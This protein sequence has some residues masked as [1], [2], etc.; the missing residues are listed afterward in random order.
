MPEPLA[1]T[2]MLKRDEGRLTERDNEDDATGIDVRPSKEGRGPVARPRTVD[3][4][5]ASGL[6]E[7]GPPVLLAKR[8]EGRGMAL[9]S[10]AEY[11]PA[12]VS[13]VAA[14]PNAQAELMR[15]RK[16]AIFAVR[17]FIMR[18]EEPAAAAFAESVGRRMGVR[19]GRLLGVEATIGL[20]AVVLAREDGLSMR[21]TSAVAFAV[22]LFRA[23]AESEARGSSG[24]CVRDVGA[25]AG[26]DAVGC[27]CAAGTSRG[28]LVLLS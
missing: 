5:D 19:S 9:V 20:R 28:V 8:D 24:V 14:W 25:A 13:G 1:P 17:S 3:V 26:G 11:T 2:P 22:L 16:A 23:W 18:T 10:A 7:F 21:E 12:S 6:D 27:C 15:E 4:E